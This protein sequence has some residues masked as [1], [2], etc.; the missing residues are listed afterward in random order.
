[1]GETL[2]I[3]TA[4]VLAGMVFLALCLLVALALRRR[5]LQRGGGTVDCSLRLPESAR[6]AL[7]TLGVGR[8]AGDE[9]QWFRL[10][11]FAM[12]PQHV[13]LRR[14]LVVKERRRPSDAEVMALLVGA[15]VV[16]CMERGASVELAMSESALTGF[17]AWLESA[18]PGAYMQRIV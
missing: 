6:H 2:A 9:L 14:D 7:W 16:S 1:M 18:P 17:L 4:G 5:M 3:D 11:S 15:V 13:I 12:R 10:F 8:Y